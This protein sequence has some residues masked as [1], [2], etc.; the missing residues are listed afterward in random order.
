VK[1]GYKRA[2]GGRWRLV[3]FAQYEHLGSAIADSPIVNA[4]GVVT[5][6]AGANYAF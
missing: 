1:L 4:H 5:L 2:L 3:A 6:F